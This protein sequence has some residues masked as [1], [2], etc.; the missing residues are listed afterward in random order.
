MYGTVFLSTPET[1][2]MFSDTFPAIFQR[3][4]TR[5]R[6]ARDT[7]IGGRVKFSAVATAGVLDT[8]FPSKVGRNPGKRFPTV[9]CSPDVLLIIGGVH[10][11]HESVWVSVTFCCRGFTAI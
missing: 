7:L 5:S 10:S 4:S 9:H 2:D 8:N 3:I 1:T 11:R 6:T